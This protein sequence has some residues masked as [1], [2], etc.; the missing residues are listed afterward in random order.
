VLDVTDTQKVRFG[1]ARVVSPQDL[2]LLGLGTTYNFTRVTG[3]RTNIHTGLQD[4]FA[5][6]G[7]NA[8]N[9]NL[10]PYRASQFNLSYENYFAEN[11]LVSVA[12]FYKQVDNFVVIENIPTLINDD[13][14]GTTR[15]VKTP[16]NAGGARIYG[17]EVGGQYAFG[18]DISPWLTGLGVAANYTHSLSSS[19]LS[20]SFSSRTPIPGVAENALTTTLFYERFGFSARASYSWQGKSVYD[21][22]YGSTFQFNDQN[23]NPKVYEVFS[24]PYGQLDGQLGYDFSNHFGVLASAQNLT[25]AAQHTYLQWPN[26]PFTYDQSGRR[27]FVGF[28]FKY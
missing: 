4:G 14:G 28:K 26:Q 27:F 10:D 18:S 5:F 21:G 19:A 6:D 16:E 17:F 12:G 22:V 13:F 25:N 15:T 11:G 1:A 3:T 7:G 20:T 23:N 8:G 24:A 9:Q 2:F